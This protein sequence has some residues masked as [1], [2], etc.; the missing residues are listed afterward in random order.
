MYNKE[1]LEKIQ[2]IRDLTKQLDYMKDSPSEKYMTDLINTLIFKI[3][4]TNGQILQKAVALHDQLTNLGYTVLLDN[5]DERAG[6][7]F[8][9]ADLIGIPIK[10]IVGSKNAKNDLVEVKDRKT[11]KVDQIPTKDLKSHLESILK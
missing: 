6:V 2:L 5:R 8:K 1:L 4:A 7:K 9:D 10:I 11:G 3:D